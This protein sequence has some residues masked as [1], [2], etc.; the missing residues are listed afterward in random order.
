MALPV[1]LKKKITMSTPNANRPGS[2]LTPAGRLPAH[3]QYAKLEDVAEMFLNGG[4]PSRTVD[5]YWDGDIPWITGAD[6][7][8]NRIDNIRRYI[9]QAGVKNSATNVINKGELL[10]V[11][12][13]G[14]G[15]IAV[16]PCNIAVSQD[17]TGVY[18]DKTRADVLFMLY[19]ICQN[20][21]YFKNCNQGTSINGITR[22]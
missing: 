16:A 7:I 12:R 15:K 9:T 4:T 5:E 22:P 3:W 14:V 11:T 6:I 20:F 17:I 19:L 18:L 10:V 1:A 21:S 13:T 2:Q 8:D